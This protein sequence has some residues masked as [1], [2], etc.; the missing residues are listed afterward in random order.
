MH[1]AN[2]GANLLT[3]KGQRYVEYVVMALKNEMNVANMFA[4]E[5]NVNLPELFHN[6]SQFNCNTTKTEVNVAGNT[7]PYMV[8]NG[9]YYE[10]N[11]LTT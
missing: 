6:V 4:P 10:N 9:T 1:S 11:G 2:T 3:I 8:M 5:R 7:W